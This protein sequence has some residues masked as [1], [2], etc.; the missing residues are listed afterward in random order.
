MEVG[1]R[2]VGAAALLSGARQS[3]GGND[4][5]AMTKDSLKSQRQLLEKAWAVY[6]HETGQPE[7]A[8]DIWQSWQRSSCSVQPNRTYAPVDDPQE[9]LQEWRDS[10]LYAAAK[11]LLPDVQKTAEDQDFIV[12][13]CD[14]RG[15][16][17]WTHSGRHMQRRAADLHFVPG[18]H[19]DEVSIGTNALAMA[20]RTAKPSQV[21]SAEHFIQAVH[22]WVCYSAPIRDPRNGL[23]VGVLN[24]STTWQKA[25]ALGLTTATALA[26]YV[27]ERLGHLSPGR[28]LKQRPVAWLESLDPLPYAPQRFKLRLCGTPQA[29]FEGERLELP[30][31]R[32][33]IFAL[34]ALH[35][36]GLNLDALHAKLYGDQ[37]VSFSTLKAE[38]SL[39][40]KQLAG[41][42]A[43]RP[44]RLTESCFVDCLSIRESL[45][46]DQ[47]ERALASYRGKLL[48]DSE[49]PFLSEWRDFLD[50]AVR[51]AV[52]HADNQEA[53]WLYLLREQDDVEVL[54]Q[55]M[56]RL[57]DADPRLPLVKARLKL[58]GA[59]IW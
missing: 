19:W 21:F 33:E 11:P 43:S 16:L 2:L 42:V 32:L 7:I 24:L 50:N 30:P 35:P 22:D 29:W 48:P 28:S 34:L 5:V 49:S 18:G 26:R 44:Y 4:R 13:I 31:R 55:L 58:V 10:A 39:L 14:G 17:L 47:L 57:P 15:K 38:V 54:I 41:A 25:N 37:P 1:K 9:T 3:A 27:E 45:C 20:L 23:V 6:V 51:S 46:A 36:K 40:R 12:G 8:S 59:E 56:Q 52:L 53:M